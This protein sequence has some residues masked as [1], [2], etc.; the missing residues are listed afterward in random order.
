MVDKKQESAH[1]REKWD[2]DARAMSKNL[3]IEDCRQ[4]METMRSCLQSQYD[5]AEIYSPARVVKRANNMGMRGGFSLDFT[6]PDSDGYI[7][8]FSKHECRQKAFKNI[9]E[10]RPYMIVGSPDCTPFPIIQNLK[11]R[12]PEGEEKVKRARGEGTKHL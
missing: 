2:E 4:A 11:M 10:C 3:G 8:D 7:W 5:L 9:R 1:R 6:G 12:T